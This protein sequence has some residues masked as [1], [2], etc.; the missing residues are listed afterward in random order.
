MENIEDYRDASNI[1]NKYIASFLLFAL[2][3]TFGEISN[4]WIKK[5]KVDN[6]Q[7][8]SVEL[9]FYF[10]ELGGI[11]SIN[12]D[13]WMVS[14]NT[15]L[16]MAIANSILSNFKKYKY[17]FN[18]KTLLAY[19][20]N[21][22]DG[23]KRI[24]IDSSNNKFRKTD[25]IIIKNQ[26]KILTSNITDINSIKLSYNTDSFS[27]GAAAYCCPIGIAF[28]GADNRELLIKTAIEQS[29]IT[30]NTAFGYLG[31]LTTALFSAFAIENTD[32]IKWVPE[33]IIIL[34]SEYVKNMIPS[35]ITEQKGYISYVNY[36]RKYYSFRFDDNGKPIYAK[37]HT[38]IIFRLQFYYNEF[39]KDTIY[40]KENNRLHKKSG[41]TG[42]NVS[43]MAYD[44]LL[45]CD[46]KWEKLVIYSAVHHANGNTVCAIA[47]FLYGLVYGMGDVPNNNLKHLEFF[48]EIYNIADKMHKTFN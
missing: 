31:G 43:I 19:H 25:E 15:I 33:L 26:K 14:G 47:G 13:G 8:L 23:I 16:I 37:A 7:T 2:G 4:Y 42:L 9:L 39:T 36:W 38:N 1:W 30:H 40:F 22:L 45:D 20:N 10:I 29:K 12:L 28:Y 18:E 35:D 11:N 6:V 44:C 3:D 21:I 32:I 24:S 46:G 34:D 5:Y 17:S 48:D 41:E 27:Y